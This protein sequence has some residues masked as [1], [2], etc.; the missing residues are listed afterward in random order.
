MLR[1]TES[2]D[3]AQLMVDAVV[4]SDVSPADKMQELA[5]L[6]HSIAAMSRIGITKL[7][8]V[9]LMTAEDLIS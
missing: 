8:P 9:A 4:E 7:K 6:E 5:D 2:P 3:L 1:S